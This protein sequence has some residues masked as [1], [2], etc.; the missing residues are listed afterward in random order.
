MTFDNDLSPE[1]SGKEQL[2]SHLPIALI[3]VGVIGA[4]FALHLAVAGV[5]ALAA[6]HLVAGLGLMTFRLHRSNGVS[7]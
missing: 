7:K 5:L 4:F 6:V 1:Q 3:A 2:V